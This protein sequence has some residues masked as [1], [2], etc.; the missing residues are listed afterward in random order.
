M[1]IRD[2]NC[3]FLLRCKNSRGLLNTIWSR[4]TVLTVIGEES[5]SEQATLI[6]H[7]YGGRVIIKLAAR[8]SIPFEI[9]NIILAYQPQYTTSSR[10]NR[11]A[12]HIKSANT[13]PVE[14]LVAPAIDVR[15]VYKRQLLLSDAQ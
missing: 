11:T 7:S 5:Y 14:K 3:L 2:R 10:N 15:D 4:C 1:C 9:T 6:G 12:I 8:E 13:K